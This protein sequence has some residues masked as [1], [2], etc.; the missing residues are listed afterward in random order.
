MSPQGK[1]AAVSWDEP[2]GPSRRPDQRPASPPPPPARA[3]PPPAPRAAQPPAAPLSPHGYVP[4]AYRP[5]P[6]AR[7]PDGYSATLEQWQTTRENIPTRDS[8]EQD[9]KRSLERAPPGEVR[10]APPPEPFPP[11]TYRPLRR[12]QWPVVQSVAVIITVAV[13]L[14]ALQV[15]GELGGFRKFLD[16]DLSKGLPVMRVYPTSSEYDLNRVMS[17]TV[18]GPEL[19]YTVFA[20]IPKTILGQQQV[21]EITTNPNPTSATA[22]FWTWSGTAVQGQKVAVIIGYHIKATLYRWNI[23][24]A[25]SG[26]VAQIPATYS[27]YLPDEYKFTP[28]DATIKSLSNQLASGTVNVFDKVDRIYHYLNDNIAYQTNSP[29]EPKWPTGTLSDKAGDCD[30]QSFLLGSLLRVQ[31]IPAWMEMGLLY[32]QSQR[33]WGAHAWLRLYI[34]LKAGGGAE[35][36]IDPANDQYLFRDANRLT[37][38]IDDGD[39]GHL[40]DYYVSWRYV[41]TG[42]PPLR[43][44]RYDAIYFRP[45]D[46]TVE[47]EATGAGPGAKALGELWKMPGFDFNL[48]ILAA[49]ASALIIGRRRRARP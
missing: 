39:G 26:T 23:D 29:A 30:D 31:G 5:Q 45:S 17:S 2:Q 35:V 38:Y 15:H 9:L 27:R 33:A 46:S 8:H 14:S 22:D 13:I 16:R 3:P 7:Q 43:E 28:T 25:N 32:D 34:P 42:G 12:K 24:S 4:P 19:S 40:E 20:G 6:A 37:D 47:I 10:P 18:R 49:A 41:Y 1:D 48:L 36:N 21:I 44:D 11:P